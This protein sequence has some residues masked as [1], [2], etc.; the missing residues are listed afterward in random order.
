MNNSEKQTYIGYD[1]KGTLDK[2]SMNL[3]KETV[4][5]IDGNATVSFKEE[6]KESQ[7]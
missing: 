7:R 2:N 4:N 3:F 6:E 1:I 5:S